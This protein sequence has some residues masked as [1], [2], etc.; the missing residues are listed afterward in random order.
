MLYLIKR[1]IL[2]C[3]NICLK[4]RNGRDVFK[5]RRSVLLSVILCFLISIFLSFVSHFSLLLAFRAQ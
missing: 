2:D 5:L 4:F 3:L 1:F